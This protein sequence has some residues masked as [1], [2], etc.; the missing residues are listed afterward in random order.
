M[1]IN[2]RK[3]WWTFSRRDLEEKAA[4]SD[5]WLSRLVR[6]TVLQTRT[7]VRSQCSSTVTTVI[8]TVTQRRAIR[9]AMEEWMGRMNNGRPPR[10]HCWGAASLALSVR[11]VSSPHPPLLTPADIPHPPIAT[12]RSSPPGNM[13]C[14]HMTVPPSNSLLKVAPELKAL[15]FFTVAPC[16]VAGGCGLACSVLL[17]TQSCRRHPSLV[18][19]PLTCST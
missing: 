16:S 10:W 4:S 2:I 3:A 12:S 11:W 19:I 7:F 8:Y 17:H 18:L 9:A 13:Q 14:D 6:K 15:F 1:D 5:F